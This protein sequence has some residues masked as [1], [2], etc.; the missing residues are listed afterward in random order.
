MRDKKTLMETFQERWGS[1]GS[2]RGMNE[3][4]K[5]MTVIEYEEPT[6]KAS[7]C[8]GCKV[9]DD[10]A[11]SIKHVRNLYKER[12]EGKLTHIELMDKN[13]ERFGESKP[14]Y[15]K[16]WK[17][18]LG[19][20]ITDFIKIT[21]SPSLLGKLPIEGQDFYHIMR[22]NLIYHGWVLPKVDKGKLSFVSAY[23]IVPKS[24]VIP[25]QTDFVPEPDDLTPEEVL[26]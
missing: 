23:P 24:N 5:G 14:R 25:L 8:I 19:E 22:D 2:S 12:V 4:L 21:N 17:E 9:V 15:R 6:C 26:F 1:M 11:D 18:V 10:C 7:S 3:A 16:H 20:Y 13:R